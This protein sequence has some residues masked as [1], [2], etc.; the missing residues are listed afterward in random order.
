V[1]RLMDRLEAAGVGRRPVV[2]AAHSMG[3]LLVKEMLARS[4]EEGEGGRHAALAAATRGVVFYGTP[5]FGS[6]LAAAAW[7]LRP[8]V[9]GAALAPAV[10]RLT[11]GPHLVELNE[12][13]RQLHDRAGLEVVAF[14]EGQPT[15]LAGFIP[16]LLVVPFESAYPGFGQIHVLRDHDHIEVC[17]PAS[18]ADLTYRLLLG[19][20]RRA[21]AAGGG[22]Q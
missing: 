20:V 4:L 17:K 8:Y 9:P 5:H 21:A 14:S 2:F 13:L 18:R 16:K 12:R 15:A 19:M 6:S 10:A 1:T 22:G 11:P 3:G 7:R